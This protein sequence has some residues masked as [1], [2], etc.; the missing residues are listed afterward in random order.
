MK[1]LLFLAI[2]L[3]LNSCEPTSNPVDPTP[4]A[5]DRSLAIE[6]QY[7]F[8]N[9]SLVMNQINY[10]TGRNTVGFSNIQH[11]LSDLKLKKADGSWINVGGY[12]LLSPNNQAKATFAF[13]DVPKGVY[14]GI[15]FT[16]GVDS[17]ANHS[18]PAVWPNDHALSMMIGGSMHWTWNSGYIF[19]KVEGQYDIPGSTAGGFAYHIGRDDLKVIYTQEGINLNL[20]ENNGT[21]VFKMDLKKFFDQPNSF[22]IS[23]ETSFTHSGVRDTVA[24]QLHQN[25]QSMVSFIELKP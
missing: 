23:P 16:L 17:L 1:K 20:Q 22:T 10:N 2:I 19:I 12:G 13:R 3:G 25:M 15:R 8:D 5:D 14:E 11:F 24:E 21:A 6:M 18:D 9:Q 4:V 7:V